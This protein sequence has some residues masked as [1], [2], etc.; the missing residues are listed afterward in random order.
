M[1]STPGAAETEASLV[2]A[3]HALETLAMSERER[4]RAWRRDRPGW[5]LVADPPPARSC[6][7]RA[8]IERPAPSLPDEASVV[9]V[10][11]AP[12]DTP[13]QRTRP[14]IRRRA[15]AAPA[16]RSVRSAR[17]PR[18]SARRLLSC[19]RPRSRSS[20]DCSISAMRRLAAAAL[21]AS[22]AGRAGARQNHQRRARNRR[23]SPI[24][25][26]HEH[27]S[28]RTGCARSTGLNPKSSPIASHTPKIVCD[29]SGS[30]D[31]ILLRRSI[32]F[33]LHWQIFCLCH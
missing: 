6:C 15:A 29:R 26:L 24:I 11:D 23:R 31:V 18:R 25:G 33:K 19:L 4:L 30:G 17:S 13:G 10:I 32:S 21:A 28:R 14:G 16:P 2:A 8:G 9:A 27:R 3:R 12:A 22:R 20:F 1:P 5:R 7:C